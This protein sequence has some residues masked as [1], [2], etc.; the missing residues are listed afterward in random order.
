VLQLRVYG[1]TA[2]MSAAAGDLE[3]L[4]G[5]RHVSVAGGHGSTTVL[6]ADLS[7][8]AADDALALLVGMGVSPD[9]VVLV[10]LETIGP[11]SGSGEPL[12]I[13]WADVLGRARIQA[14]APVRYF[15]LMVAAGVVASFAVIDASP[16]LI[17]GAMAI[18]PDL[19]PI[20]AVCTG[21]VLGRLRLAARGL[22]TLALGLG[23]ICATAAFVTALLELF[24]VLPT[25]FALGEIPAGQTHVGVSTILVALA[26]G[27]A[28]M[29]AVETR[30]SS[31]VGVAIS[32]TTVPAVA[33]LGVAAGIGE[34]SKALSALAVLGANVAMMLV[35]GTSA[36]AVQRLAG[37][38]ARA[39]R[40]VALPSFPEPPGQ[41]SA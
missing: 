30:A 35:G 17:V 25:G 37:R 3:A 1:Q 7:A 33:Y 39:P 6:T 10:Q 23:V 8:E 2:A 28:G 38:R 36:L 21:F 20:I 16:V 34:L 22:A 13:V 29:L 31:A 15:V 14:R 4:P 5:A 19:L 40:A 41:R 11:A 24:S 27:V 18:S 9:D 12:S 32:V 26:A